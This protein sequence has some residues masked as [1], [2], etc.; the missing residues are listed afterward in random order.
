MATAGPFST[1]DSLDM[2][3]LHDVIARVREEEP[4]VLLL[5]SVRRKIETVEL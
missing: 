3:P 2:A 5:V 1:C 4:H